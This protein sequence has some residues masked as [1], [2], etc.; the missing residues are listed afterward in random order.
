[1]K[2]VR[3]FGA[4]CLAFL[5]RGRAERELE[6]EVSA[7]LAL[8]EED[9]QRRGLSP[10]NAQM[11]ARRAYGSVELAK[12][13]HRDARSFVWL[14]QAVQDLRH[15][16]RAL[17]RSPGFAALAVLT[18]ALGVGVNTTLF[19]A[20]NALALRPLPVTGPDR[21]V[22]LE[23]WLEAGSIGDVQYHFSYPEYVYCRD[24]NGI[25]A[26]MV[27]G[28][29]NVHVLAHIDGSSEPEKL[30]GQLVSEN[31]FAV[32]GIGA[33][34]GRTF[35]PADART[36]VL[37]ISSLFWQRR[38]GS[39]PG[40][41]GHTMEIRG[42]RYTVIGVAE[43]GFTST[44]VNDPFSQFW[45]PL[46]MQAQLAPPRNWLDDPN[47]RQI[48]LLARLQPTVSMDRAQAE[49]AVLFGQFGRTY[50]E[51]DRT[52]TV[53]LQHTSL[54][55]N[56][57]DP[58]FRGAVAGVMMLVGLVLL[59]ACANIAN[60]LLARAATRQRE[61]GVR[62]SMGAG[63]GR[64]IRHM[65]T[66]SLLLSFLGGLAGLLLALWTNRMLAV[67]SA[68]VLAGTPLDEGGFRLDL[69]MDARVLAYALALSLV[70]GIFFG[71]APAL[72]F[73]R[74]DLA[75]A[76]KEGGAT[77]GRTLTR[78]RLRGFLVGAQVTVSMMLLIVAGMLLRGL[79][80]SHD[81]DPGFETRH[82]FL[83]SADFGPG[84]G[85]EA[86]ARLLDRFAA[87][88]ELH[89]TASGTFPMM[90]TWTPLITV[91]SSASQ[92]PLHGRTLASYASETYLETLG[93][94]LLRGRTFTTQEVRTNAPVAII[95]AGAAR[96]FW[97][98][99]DPIGKRFQLDLRFTG[100]LTEFEVI[101]V[102]ADARTANLTRVDPAHVYLTPDPAFG[103]QGILVRAAGD[104]RRGLEA[105][106]A[107]VA[108][109]DRN[110]LPGLWLT[111]MQ[112]GPMVREKTQ[113]GML[114]TFATI[115][116]GLA[117]MLAGVGIYGVMSYLVAQRVKEI[118]VR[119]A[120]GA[121]A[122]GVLRSVVLHSLRPVTWGMAIGIAGAA[123]LSS[124]LHATLIMPGSTDLFY[125]IP[126]YDPATFGGLAAFLTVVAAAASAVP[127]R[128]AT[129]VD[130]MIALR[131][132]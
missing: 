78:S 37:V 4:R 42:T 53:T 23:R 40:I 6:R 72:Q 33:Q 81:A 94:P 105:I 115:L 30:T 103:P 35:L 76:I 116:A 70:A 16:A 64:L 128:R 39:D 60:M 18:L 91:Q 13:L 75:T 80:R 69:S 55:G 44:A 31:Y 28:S 54:L 61:I 123:A 74:P 65:L 101:G 7:H 26:G 5:R 83:M 38:F 10:H 20:Y 51:R 86:R 130:P 24:H 14:E 110:L 88:R 77:F 29:P 129:R 132:E 100:K 90:G 99:A 127:A 114:A 89:S 73:T 8:L 32:L 104:P 12:E 112:D 41:L 119:M 48:Q 45:A 25:F 120:L 71:L 98:T 63:R 62:L 85:Q 96:S 52:R 66:E 108:E 84:N 109:I 36:P 131:C 121:T 46:S 34:L 50:Q 19:T 97:P 49:T 107:A 106:R 93:V 59:V 125:G 47:E 27:A 92:A 82:L 111:S 58:R 117:L 43:P 9:F 67:F 124:V 126:F 15:A 79:L 2:A 3:R 68:R 95:S 17:R 56:T 118:G 113:A 57:E 102:A 11:A 122:A 22:R 1:M 87:R 21:V